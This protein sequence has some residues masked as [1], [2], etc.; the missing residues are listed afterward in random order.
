[1]KISRI[2]PVIILAF[3]ASLFCV[4]VA[5]ARSRYSDSPREI[6]IQMKTSRGVASQIY[7]QVQ[8]PDF[9]LYGDGRVVFSRTDHLEN[10]FLY[11]A[12]LDGDYINFLL[13]YLESEG[14]WDMNENY[15]NLTVEGL[16]TTTI[17][18]RTRE[19]QKSI[20]V[21]GLLLAARQRMIPSGLA[22]IY[23]QLT[24]FNRE[25]EVRYNPDKITLLVYRYDGEIP[26]DANRI[27]WKVSGIKLADYAHQEKSLMVRYKETVITGEE[28]DKIL[29]FILDKTLYG[30]RAGFFANF[31][32]NHRQLFK[33]A[34]RPHLP[35]E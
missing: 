10:Q 1:M 9:T 25:D 21:Y 12:K 11:E 26:Q 29:G 30:N 14:F 27:N 33:V 2:I 3:M 15:L 4:S 32:H 24:E 5:T 20:R 6:I 17:S 19:K 34:Y 13:D 7:R 28:K 35:Y 31:F 23:R 18:V 22:N 8:V 16:D